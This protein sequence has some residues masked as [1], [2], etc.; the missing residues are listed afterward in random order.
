MRDV[1][2]ILR[3]LGNQECGPVAFL[4]ILSAV[5][6]SSWPIHLAFEFYEPG[7]PGSS[8]L[9]AK[10]PGSDDS[11]GAYYIGL[12]LMISHHS[13][14]HSLARVIPQDPV[15]ADISPSSIIAQ[16]QFARAP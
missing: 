7:E 13:F 8:R 9:W 1:H 2:C 14:D 3:G 5:V 6:V 16:N 12:K 4:R 11:N 15:T 10:A